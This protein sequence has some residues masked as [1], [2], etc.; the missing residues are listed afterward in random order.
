[1]S[2]KLTKDH[3]IKYLEKGCLNKAINKSKEIDIRCLWDNE[4][5]VN[6]KLIDVR[7]K[8]QVVVNEQ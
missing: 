8:N 4:K 3:I 1:M 6:V 7:Q 5:F 2:Y